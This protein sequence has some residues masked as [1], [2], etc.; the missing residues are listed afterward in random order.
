MQANTKRFGTIDIP[1]EKIIVLENGMIG[2][3][4][5]QK[6]ALIFDAEKE[7]GGKI[8]W[9]QSMDEPDISFPVMDP[10]IIKKDYN[11]MIND[12][13]LKPLGELTADNIFVLSTVTVPKEL[14]KMSIN[15]KAPIV[16]NSDTKKG[17]QII[18]EDD[19]PV[20]FK[21]YELLKN[22]K[23]KAGE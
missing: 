19:F 15:L 14:E 8:K 22:K 1:D 18:V 4:E 23:E 20:K 7:D 12:E 10:T 6:F 11:P 16:I 17:A 5:L 3:P 13:I 2:F 21:V 9:L